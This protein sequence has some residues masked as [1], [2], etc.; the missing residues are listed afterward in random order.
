MV[1]PTAIGTNNPIH[2]RI[3]NITNLSKIPVPGSNTSGHWTISWLIPMTPPSVSFLTPFHPRK[4]V[5]HGF[6][7]KSYGYRHEIRGTRSKSFD[8]VLSGVGYG[9]DPV[10]VLVGIRR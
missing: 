7:G 1:I 6:H 10:W 3:T 4:C 2:P 5:L 8:D 9:R